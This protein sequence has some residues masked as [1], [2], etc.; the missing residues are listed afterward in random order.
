M[1]P[2]VTVTD[3]VPGVVAAAVSALAEEQWRVAVLVDAADTGERWDVRLRPE[4]RRRLVRLGHFSAYSL[5]LAWTPRE[6]AGHLRDSARVFTERIR[7]IRTE[8][9]PPL[10]DFVTDAPVRLADYRETDPQDLVAQLRTAQAELLRAVAEVGPADLERTGIHETDGPVRV[11][12]LLAFL[13][14]HQ[15][16]HAD[17]LW[18][19]LHR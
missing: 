4:Q 9:A 2:A 3:P 1:L 18:A 6:V 12:D 14:E 15:R 19:L 10:A 17:Q 16:D 7:R 11:T 8:S 13:P 5:E